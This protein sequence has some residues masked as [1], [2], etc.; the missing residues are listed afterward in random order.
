MS[1]KPF[2]KDEKKGIHEY[3][4]AISK[5]V[6]EEKRT[7]KK[8]LPDEEKHLSMLKRV[9]RGTSDGHMVGPKKR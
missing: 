8:I 3:K 2:I 7:Y 4:K 9:G 6:G 1:T 5:S